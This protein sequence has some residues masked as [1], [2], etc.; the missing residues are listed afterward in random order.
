[1][2]TDWSHLEQSRV[3]KGAYASRTGDHFGAF[4]FDKG[5]KTIK[6]IATDGE[7]TGWEHVSVSASVLNGP[8]LIGM[9]P[10][11]EDMCWI[12]EQFWTDEETVM[13][14]H[15]P[16]S[17]YINNHKHCLHLWRPTDVEIPLPPSVFVGLKELNK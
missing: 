13:Q 14:L 4:L 2:K 9:M 8:Y 5:A 1:M 7:N 12:K 10:A 16:K 3:R 6:V 15:P 17:E 11:W